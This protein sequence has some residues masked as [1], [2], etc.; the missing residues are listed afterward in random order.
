MGRK[1]GVLLND[2]W[3]SGPDPIDHKLY[4]DCMKARA[5]AYYRGE[6]WSISEQEYIELWR[7]DDRYLRKGRTRH[8][9]CMIRLDPRLPWSVD[10]VEII[11]RLDHFKTCSNLTKGLTNA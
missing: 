7:R 8:S 9:L 5:Q 3:L 11:S 2:V 4:N 1:K 10:N 6:Q